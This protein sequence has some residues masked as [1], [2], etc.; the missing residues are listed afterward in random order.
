MKTKIKTITTVIMM[1]VFHFAGITN[2]SAQE[3][4]AQATKELVKNTFENGVVINNETVEVL[5]P[6][7]MDFVIEHRFGSIVDANGDLD[8]RN[9]L[10]LYSPANIRMGLSYGVLKNLTFGIGTAK[11][12][13]TYDIWGK[14]KILKQEKNGMPVTLTYFGD[15][16]VNTSNAETMKN[17]EG[18]VK[19]TNRMS[20]FHEL[21]V[22]HKFN[23]KIAVQLSFAYTHYNM[24][25]SAV[26]KGIKHDAM[27]V[28]FVGKYKF[29][30]QSSVILQYNQPLETRE[31]TKTE[32][33][34]VGNVTSVSTTKGFHPKPDLGI[35]LEVSTGS[36]Q[37]QIFVCTSDAIV[38]QERELYNTN[39]FT[40]KQMLIGFNI[41][42]Q[43]GF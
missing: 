23:S 22:A 14:Y 32:T 27:A 24:V 10:G 13:Y 40:Q 41:T 34:T 5:T 19:F 1:I 11:L 43:W 18:A 15:I 6:K 33:T 38:L 21:M 25:D 16:A 20:Y 26:Y 17:A 29:S 4:S 39:D 9:L 2:I 37:F 36:H 8:G 31:F 7:S 12:K 30:P 35:G 3:E 28:A 42:R